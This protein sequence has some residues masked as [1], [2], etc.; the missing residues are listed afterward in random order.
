[1]WL[2][3]GALHALLGV[4]VALRIP[5]SRWDEVREHG[6]CSRRSA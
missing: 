5:R 1:V 4:V 6:P 2:V 3:L